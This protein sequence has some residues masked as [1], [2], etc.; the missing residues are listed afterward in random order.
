MVGRTLHH[1]GGVLGAQV[2]L[3]EPILARDVEDIADELER[4]DRCAFDTAIL[5]VFEIETPLQI[6]YDALLALVEIRQ[7]VLDDFSV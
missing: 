1:S 4:D 2:K 5:E 7:T 3:Y 6:I